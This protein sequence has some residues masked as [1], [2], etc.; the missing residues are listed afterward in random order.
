MLKDI[1]L[2]DKE[3]KFNGLHIEAPGCIINIRPYLTTMDGKAVTSI[4]VIPDKKEA[5]VFPDYPERKGMN[6][7]VYHEED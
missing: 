4:E 5:G 1:S 6:I 7:R 2:P 3:R